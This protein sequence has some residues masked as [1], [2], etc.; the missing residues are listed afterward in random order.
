MIYQ[1]QALGSLLHP[2][3]MPYNENLPSL[4]KSKTVPKLEGGFVYRELLAI[5]YVFCSLII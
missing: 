5:S 3:A 1:I 4:T 2:L